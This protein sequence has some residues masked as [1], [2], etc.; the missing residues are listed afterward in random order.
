MHQEGN[1]IFRVTPVICDD[2]DVGVDE[3]VVDDEVAADDDTKLRER[4]IY[5]N[6]HQQPMVILTL[7][8]D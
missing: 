1:M 4:F 6:K 7:F 3:V 2:T 8:Q 5:N